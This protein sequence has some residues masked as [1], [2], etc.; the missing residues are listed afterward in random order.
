MNENGLTVF[1]KAKAQT[2]LQN[3]SDQ[4]EKRPLFNKINQAEIL[5]FIEQKLKERDSYYTSAKKKILIE[6]INSESI[7]LLLTKS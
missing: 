3:M 2:L 4:I 5:T 1:I 7:N 6:A